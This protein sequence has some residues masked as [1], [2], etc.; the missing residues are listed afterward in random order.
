MP[1][2]DPSVAS[3][4][5]TIKNITNNLKNPSQSPVFIAVPPK[6]QK[7]I[8]TKNNIIS[9]VGVYIE[10]LRKGASSKFR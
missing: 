10:L 7:K 5:A 3:T 9:K 2:H 1:E 4:Q 8:I 6:I